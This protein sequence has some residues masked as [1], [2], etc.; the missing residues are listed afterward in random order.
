MFRSIE[1]DTEAA[2]ARGESGVVNL[3]H[4]LFLMSF[5]IVGNLMLSRDVVDSQCKEGYEFFQAMG[6]V[7]VW[8]GKPNL[9]DFFPFL[10]WLDPQGLKRNMTRDMGRALE[11]VEGFVKERIEEY[12]FGDKEK[13][14]KDFLDTL[15]EFEGDGKDWH[16]KI[17]YERLIIL[18]LV[19]IYLHYL[20]ILYY[21]L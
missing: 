21:V 15:L 16:E 11:I 1:D 2:T 9:A 20:K 18:V 8:A 17:P 3:P 19:S 7:S 10:K 12:K 13:A 4:Y 6:M 5:N 14:S